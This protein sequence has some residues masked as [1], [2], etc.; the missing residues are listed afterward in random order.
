MTYAPVAEAMIG[1]GLE[2]DFALPAYR[3]LDAGTVDAGPDA[4]SSRGRSSS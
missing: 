2:D 1:R 3:S 4:I